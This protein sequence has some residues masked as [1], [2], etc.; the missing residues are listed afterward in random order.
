MP[1]NKCRYEIIK[2][3]E[4][5]QL[6]QRMQCCDCGLVHDI[7]YDVTLLNQVLTVRLKAT[8]NNR[9]TAQVRRNKKKNI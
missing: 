2:D 3:G 7:E 8:R 5:F 1:K 9:A 6:G 4:W